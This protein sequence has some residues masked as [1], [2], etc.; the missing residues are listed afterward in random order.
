MQ[1][2]ETYTSGRDTLLLCANQCEAVGIPLPPL[3]WLQQSHWQQA[4]T[5]NSGRGQAVLI[6]DPAPMVLRDY[7]R[8]GLVRHV[9]ERRF[10]FGGL[11]A[12]RPYRELSLLN[13]MHAAGL[14]VPRGLAGR[15]S[16]YGLCYEASILMERIP[17]SCEVHEHLL[18]APLSAQQ[19]QE[20][21]RLIRTLHD[22]QVY[23]HDLNIHNIMID[24]NNKFWLIDFDKCAHKD[25]DQWKA[26][27]LSRLN[28]SLHKEQGKYAGYHFAQSNWDSL[29]S[30][31]NQPD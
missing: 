14:P 9:S 16:R 11:T 18:T 12:T 8:G 17:H 20:A 4:T 10:V 7:C 3:Q 29:Q 2:I 26:G 21:G 5:A 15:V 27:N 22:N 13:K 30:G 1:A 6:D 28:R 25:G 19:W 23:H 31:Y 24:R